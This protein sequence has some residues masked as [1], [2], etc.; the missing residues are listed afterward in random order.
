MFRPGGVIASGPAKVI[1]TIETGSGDPAQAGQGDPAQAGQG[2]PARAGQG[3]PRA[4]RCSL[5]LSLQ[6]GLRRHQGGVEELMEAPSR[7]PLAGRLLL[8]GL[9]KEL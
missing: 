2:D 8:G 1:E 5:S 9:R 4:A 7:A 3:D 6:R